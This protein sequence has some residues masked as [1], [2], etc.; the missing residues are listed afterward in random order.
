MAGRDE[1][2]EP[3]RSEMLARSLPEN[4]NWKIGCGAGSS[5]RAERSEDIAER[6]GRQLAALER[7]LSE[8]ESW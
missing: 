1:M 2:L 5:E 7:L 6:E 4:D 8:K 3:A